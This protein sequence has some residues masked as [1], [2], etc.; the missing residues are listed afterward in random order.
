L[1]AR[2]HAVQQRFQR[3][4]LDG[5]FVHVKDVGFSVGLA[6]RVIRAGWPG[7]PVSY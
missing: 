6:I 5:S 4:G 7:L 3:S 1:P 2:D